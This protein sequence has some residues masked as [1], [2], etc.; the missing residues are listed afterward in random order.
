MSLIRWD[1]F[2]DRFSLLRPF[3]RGFA[4]PFSPRG[5]ASDMA[6]DIYETDEEMVVEMAVPGIAPEDI[7]VTVT[8]NTLTVKGEIE[9]EGSI[10]RD[11]YVFRE[12]RWGRFS[13]TVTLPEGVD[14]DRVKAE[15]KSGILTLSVAKPEAA[16]AKSIKVRAK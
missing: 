4:R 13:R 6:V 16:K 9:N 11:S 8:G 15:F 5:F 1:P 7:K 10:D 3:E 12:R 14:P 2:R